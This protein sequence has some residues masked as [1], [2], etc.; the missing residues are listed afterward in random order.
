MDEEGVEKIASEWNV[1]ADILKEATW[2]LEEREG[3]DGEVYGYFVRFN[4]DN[5]P[6]I[7]IELGLRPGEF[8]REVSLN[9]FDEP[10]F[11]APDDGIYSINEPLPDLSDIQVPDEYEEGE[12]V[13]YLVDEKGNYLTDENGNRLIVSDPPDFRTELV[14]RLDRLEA[15]LGAYA[16]ALPPRSH[17]NPPE[18]L[19]PELST[20]P[21]VEDVAA[22][23][24]ALRQEAQKDMPDPAVLKEKA[25][26]LG[27]AASAMIF[28]IKVMATGIVGGAAWDGVGWVYENPQ[29]LHD[30]LV[31]VADTA[32]QWAQQ[33]F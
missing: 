21:S 25:S 8:L 30:A 22:A 12:D 33:L 4:E 28:L 16:K 23:S 19:L 14:N 27:K 10:E 7:L 32:Q 31:A 26:I 29:K 1:S 18:L 6:A 17:N 9:V 15:L 24:K 20:A 11:D 13:S 3:N 2:E 5:D